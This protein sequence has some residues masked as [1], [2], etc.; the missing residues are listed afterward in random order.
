MHLHARRLRWTAVRKS[1]PLV[2]ENNHHCNFRPSYDA[3]TSG[4]SCAWPSPFLYFPDCRSCFCSLSCI[5]A[6]RCTVLY[7][8]GACC[9][10]SNPESALWSRCDFLFW[11][12]SCSQNHLA[13]LRW[14]P[15]STA[16]PTERRG[17]HT[18]LRCIGVDESYPVIFWRVYKSQFLWKLLAGFWHIRWSCSQAPKCVFLFQICEHIS[19]IIIHLYVDRDGNDPTHPPV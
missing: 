2:F 10:T 14:T 17:W 7:H 4:M 11:I 9:S 6:S 12:F 16:E 1:F 5:R 19:F 8:F 15:Y 18:I 3:R 13:H